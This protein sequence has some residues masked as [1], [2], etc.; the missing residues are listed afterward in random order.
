MDAK[1]F[2]Q[3]LI[4]EKYL[5]YSHLSNNFTEAHYGVWYK[6]STKKIAPP[7]VPIYSWYYGRVYYTF[8]MH[9]NYKKSAY[10]TAMIWKSSTEFG[11]GRAHDNL[12]TT[13]YVAYFSPRGNIKGK[14]DENVFPVIN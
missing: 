13:Y 8:D 2:A 10:F 14:Y 6:T 12:Q 4:S 9:S 11:I 3:T 7:S 5:R 1:K